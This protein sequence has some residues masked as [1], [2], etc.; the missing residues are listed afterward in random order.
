MRDSTREGYRE[1]IGRVLAHIEANL[2]RPMTLEELAGVACFSPYHFHRIFRGMVGEGV[3]EFLRR[4][5]LERA[6][7]SLRTTRRPVT[8]IAFEAGYQSH[9]SFSR[10]FKEMT[11][12]SPSEFRRQIGRRPHGPGGFSAAGLKVPINIGGTNMEVEIKNF[13]PIR[14]AYVRHQGPYDQ[15][16]AAWGKLCAWAGPRGLLGG[17]GL[18]LGLSYDDPEVTAPDKLRYDACMEV[19]PDVAGEGDVAIGEVPGGPYAVVV[20]K[21]P[22]D[23]L[24]ETYAEF[25]GRWIPASGREMRYAPPV[26]IYIN[27]PETTP[28]EDLLVEIRLPLEK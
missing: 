21:G 15:C 18:M 11:G 6:A 16:G 24:K 10:A 5:R 4:L 9:E 13:Q 20:H 7:H 19:G 1:R 14:V 3:A 2:D 26:E 22:Y 8:R 28:P 25:C 23:R 12:R 17:D 27:D